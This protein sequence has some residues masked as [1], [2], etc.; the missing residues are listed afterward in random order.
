M[1]GGAS[2]YMWGRV[3]AAS[4]D[5]WMYPRPEDDLR[6]WQLH[7]MGCGYGHFVV[8]AD[9]SVIAWGAACASGELGFGEGGKKS[10]ARPDKVNSLEGVKVRP[11]TSARLALALGEVDAVVRRGFHVGRRA[12][13]HRSA[14]S[15]SA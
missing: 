1:G 12:L 5:C 9:S 8:S 4:Q 11:L 2:L 14:P 13:P 10:S 3:K 7:E 15:H 6:G